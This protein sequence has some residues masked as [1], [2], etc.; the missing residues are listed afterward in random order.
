MLLIQTAYQKVKGLG[1]PCAVVLR[2]LAGVVLD[3]R[4]NGAA[5]GLKQ[6]GGS[7]RR[8]VSASGLSAGTNTISLRNPHRMLRTDLAVAALAVMHRTATPG[9]RRYRGKVSRFCGLRV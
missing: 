5:S 4:A 1:L 2:I 9:P 3:V 7:A 6:G 8:A